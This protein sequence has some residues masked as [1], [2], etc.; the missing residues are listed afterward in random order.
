MKI[1][2]QLLLLLLLLSFWFVSCFAET[3]DNKFESNA[4]EGITFENYPRID[5][6]TSTKPL[7]A[8]IACKLLNIRYEWQPNL[9]SEGF[10]VKG[11]AHSAQFSLIDV[12]GNKILSKQV[13]NDE[14]IF[15][16]TLQKGLYIVQLI[17]DKGISQHKIIKK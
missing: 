15:I 14:Y 8:L 7:N 12:S 3:T 10:S 1:I 2:S 16:N 5:G 13:V 17:T 6:S 9:V 4:I 11:L